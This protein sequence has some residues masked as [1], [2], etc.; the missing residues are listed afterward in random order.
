MT[1]IELANKF[2]NEY[3]Q[4]SSVSYD[5][6][7]QIKYFSQSQDISWLTGEK[8]RAV[9][10]HLNYPFLKKKNKYYKVFDCPIKFNEQVPCIIF[11]NQIFN[12]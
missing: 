6:D 1:P 3:M 10:V 5:I 11:Q 4:Y 2:H 12:Q 7:Y 8:H 9:A